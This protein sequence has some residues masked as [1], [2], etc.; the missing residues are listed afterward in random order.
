MGGK[1]KETSK[2][3]KKGI[4]TKRGKELLELQEGKVKK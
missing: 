4:P 1:E 2:L 3:I